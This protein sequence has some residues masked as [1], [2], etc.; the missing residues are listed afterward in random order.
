MIISINKPIYSGSFNPLYNKLYY[1]KNLTS[2]YNNIYDANGFR[3][4]LRVIGKR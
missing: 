1:F 3:F 2:I 4:Q